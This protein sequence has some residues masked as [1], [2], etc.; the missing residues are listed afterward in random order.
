MI[1]AVLY[2]ILVCCKHIFIVFA[3]ILGLFTLISLVSKRE[4]ALFDFLLILY[5][6]CKVVLISFL[7]FVMKGQIFAITERLF[8]IQRGLLH[9]YWAPN[10]WA[11]YSILDLAVRK[12][13]I[14]RPSLYFA[15]YKK[16]EIPTST[17]CNGVTG[18]KTFSILPNVTPLHTIILIGAFHMV[19]SQY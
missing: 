1:G 4:T 19:T 10:F 2:S 18:D 15:I 6:C 11:L 5:S 3:P 9:S 16:T 14:Y 12:L 7:P 8:P 17:L 13:F